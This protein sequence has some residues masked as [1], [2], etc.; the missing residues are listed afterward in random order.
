MEVLFVLIPVSI[1][2]AA[3]SLVACLIAIRGGQYDDLESPKWRILFEDRRET[4]AVGGSESGKDQLLAK[5]NDE[6]TGAQAQRS[7]PL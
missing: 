7:T 4:R 2:L 5:R 1:A 3:A 6:Q